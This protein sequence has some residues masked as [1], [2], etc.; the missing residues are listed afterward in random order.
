MAD[1]VKYLYGTETQILA[2]TPD[3]AN[4]K[5]KAFYYPS[6]K[7]YFFQALGGV[8]KR[9]GGGDE[10]GIGIRLN[11][12]IIGGVKSLIDFGDTLDIPVNWEYNVRRLTVNGKINA[13][14]VINMI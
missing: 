4:W 9:Y 7:A 11:G 13:L 2:L 8:M 10:S 1:L 12:S 5:E 3:S 14:G 6:D